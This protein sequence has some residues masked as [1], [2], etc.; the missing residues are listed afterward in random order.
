MELP[1]HFVQV[2]NSPVLVGDGTENLP[3][4]CGQPVLIKGYQPERMLG[5]SVRCAACGAVTTTPDLPAGASLSG[6]VMAFERRA[7][8]MPNAAVMPPGVTF[9][10]RATVERVDAALRPRPP[11]KEPVTVSPAMLREVIEAYDRLTG[12]A[13]AAHTEAT[14]P[15]Y[16]TGI[17]RYPL[18]WACL[19][20][21]AWLAGSDLPLLG[22]VETTVAA[23]HV[24]AF[25]QFLATWGHH[26][27][28]PEMAACAAETGFGV[29]EMAVFA[30]LGVL[31]DS[32]NRIGL[33][34]ASDG[35]RNIRAWSVQ[36]GNR[37]LA[38]ETPA[39]PYFAWP[40]GKPWSPPAIRS[41]L[42]DA[43][44]AARGRINLRNPG[45]LVLSVG[46]LPEGFDQPMQ[47]GMERLLRSAGRANRG[48]A[49]LAMITPRV[50]RTGRPDEYG[51]GWL[52]RPVA[53]PAF[54]GDAKVDTT[55][56]N[57]A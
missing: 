32:G 42:E 48:V 24:G 25:R 19:H 13:Y 53:N 46:S 41:T 37:V 9:A 29:H 15:L 35:T 30:A 57:Q 22:P 7:Q 11:A 38:L 31:S 21:Q 14:L 27:L 28:F 16:W 50:L 12:G 33:A 36:T 44:A 17:R 1:P 47:E 6:T 4:G 23:A 10:D 18:A 49:A 39:F 2:G 5:L 54:E 20:L 55:P 26:A 40:D 34:P 45:I 51:F 8:E 43:I 52:F 3:C 56:R